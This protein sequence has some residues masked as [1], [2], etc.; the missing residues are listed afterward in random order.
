[1]IDVH[2]PWVPG[3]H[4]SVRRFAP[5]C[6]LLLVTARSV[7]ISGGSFGPDPASDHA[8]DA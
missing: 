8:S 2:T 6:G 5:V 7:I 1:M 3:L 4:L